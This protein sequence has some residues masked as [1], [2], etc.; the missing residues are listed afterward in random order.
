M[1]L[2][3]RKG[4]EAVLFVTFIVLAA[5][6]C[7]L[8]ITGTDTDEWSIAINI[9]MFVIVFFV[10]CFA[11]KK[12][13]CVRLITKELNKAKG[14]ILADAQN[15]SNDAFLWEKYK[16]EDGKG[17][18]G[19]GALKEPYQRFCRYMLFYEGRSRGS[20]RSDIGD[21]LNQEYIDSKASK[22]ILNTIPGVMTGLGILGTF[23]GLSVGLQ[24]FNTGSA[25]E[26]QASIAPLMNGIKIAFHTSVYG[27]I[28]SLVFNWVSKIMLE[29]SYRSLDGFLEEFDRYVIGDPSSYNTSSTQA[30][31]ADIPEK[32]A[33]KFGPFLDEVK[34]LMVSFNENITAM[35]QDR[36]DQ[37]IDKYID[38]LNDTTRK[39]FDELNQTIEHTCE[40]QRQSLD[41][42]QK[43]LDEV[44]HMTM[45]IKEVNELTDKT[46]EH[47][48]NFIGGVDELQKAVNKNVECVNQQLEERE[49]TEIRMR[50]VI[51]EISET[52][53][54]LSNT[55]E[56]AFNTINGFME[57]VKELQKATQDDLQKLDDRL[58]ESKEE[59]NKLTEFIDVIT[60]SEKMLNEKYSILLSNLESA[61][62]KSGDNNTKLEAY[63]QS[64]GELQDT[65]NKNMTAFN[66]QMVVYRQMEDK[67]ATYMSKL[68]DCEIRLAEDCSKIAADLN[69][70]VN[71]S[72]NTSKSM[73]NA[74]ASFSKSAE[75]IT[76]SMNESMNASFEQFD[77]NLAVITQHLSG[78]ISKVDETTGRVPAVVLSAYEGM[79][80]SFNELKEKT[81]GII[82]AM[83]VMERNLPKF[84]DIAKE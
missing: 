41:Y 52:E 22:D 7:F 67:M 5:I 82:Y 6:C 80:T 32:T 18:F 26:I 35:Q 45:D 64:I 1:K 58:Q 38:A 61:L 74:A 46:V 27:M 30:L 4:G 55:T 60:D 34:K 79:E 37:M 16:N 25:S 12:L 84:K 66:K 17:L 62:D 33:E 13:H 72:E 77:D 56:N 28:F 49:K 71:M 11:C 51:S 29:D 20:F 21:F 36:M 83:E 43:I 76:E 70:V 14:K 75:H 65:V 23:I 40:F 2:L 44:G 10:L 9:G 69:S 53:T 59:Q 19:D 8:M 68:S 63:I 24:S 47:M 57:S 39:N 50:S 48:T 42:M 15:N 78:T 31:L 81:E 73:E 3:V 54:A